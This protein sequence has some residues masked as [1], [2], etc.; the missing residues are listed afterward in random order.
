MT[1]G[2]SVPE[3][4]DRYQKVL[5][6]NHIANQMLFYG[7]SVCL[8]LVHFLRGGSVSSQARRRMLSYTVITRFKEQ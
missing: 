4:G 3:K 7:T 2:A 5:Q 6:I 8:L 1:C